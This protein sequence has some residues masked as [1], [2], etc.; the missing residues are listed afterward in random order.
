MKQGEHFYFATSFLDPLAVLIVC[1]VWSKLG[2]YTQA[3]DT[4]APFP[5]IAPVSCKGSTYL[6]KDGILATELRTGTTDSDKFY[7]FRGS[8]ILNMHSYSTQIH[9]HHG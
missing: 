6:M 1:S 8:V 3:L 2:L 9:T 5:T 7:V 4:I